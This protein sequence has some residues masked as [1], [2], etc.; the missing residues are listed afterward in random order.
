MKEYKE[1]FVNAEITW[2]RL[3]EAESEDAAIKIA[4]EE[5]FASNLYPSFWIDDDTDSLEE[6]F[7]EWRSIQ[8]SQPNLSDIVIVYGDDYDCG[9]VMKIQKWR[10]IKSNHMF[11]PKYWMQCP[12]PPKDTST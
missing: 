6:S 7:P 10:N 5:F 2:G 8:I 4:K 12:E 3:I 1:Y 11:K 9:E